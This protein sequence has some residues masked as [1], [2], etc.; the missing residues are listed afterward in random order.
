MPE[1]NFMV[2]GSAEDPYE[3]TF[4]R[5]DDKLLV[6]CTCPAGENRRHCK[7]RVAIMNGS[8]SNIVS[9]NRDQ[10]PTVQDWLQGTA[11][12]AA[13][14]EYNEASAQGGDAKVLAAAKV[15]LAR[16]MND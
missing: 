14:R 5:N 12:E 2:K 7:H 1:I 8:S 6:F 9:D 3:V 15:R 11:V 13:L 16:A 4:L 10:I